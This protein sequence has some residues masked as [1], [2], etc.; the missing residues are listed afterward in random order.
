MNGTQRNPDDGGQGNDPAD[1]LSP[2]R[3][4]IVLI[5]GWFELDDGEDQ[6]NLRQEHLK[7]SWVKCLPSESC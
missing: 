3:E 4:D 5:A 7:L 2:G 6:D 1:P